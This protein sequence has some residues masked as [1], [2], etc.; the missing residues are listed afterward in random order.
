[1]TFLTGIDDKHKVSLSSLHACQKHHYPIVSWMQLEFY[2][3]I[4]MV[5]RSTPWHR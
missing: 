3:E 4:I 2:M 5:W 1:L